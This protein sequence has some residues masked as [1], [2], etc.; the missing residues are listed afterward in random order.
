MIQLTIYKK[1]PALLTTAITEIPGLTVRMQNAL[2]FAGIFFVSD[3]MELNRR[4]L[5]CIADVGR[6]G[7]SLIGDFLESHQLGRGIFY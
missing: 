5:I 4:G 7:R 1:D 3:L 6:H 2:H